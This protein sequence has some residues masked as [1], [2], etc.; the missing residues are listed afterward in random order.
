MWEDEEPLFRKAV[1][2]ALRDIVGRKHAINMLRSFAARAQHRRVDCLRA[3]DRYADALIAMGNRD[4]FSETHGRVFRDAVH[5]IANLVEQAGGG[6]RVE[7]VPRPRE[8]IEGRQARA[9]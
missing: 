5:G 1:H 4:N 8:I 3:E 6:D 7:K 9:A 2:D